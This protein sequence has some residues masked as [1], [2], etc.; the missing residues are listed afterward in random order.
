MHEKPKLQCTRDYQ[1]FEGHE[2]NR[3]LHEDGRLLES[4]RKCGFMP[5][6]PIQ[7]VRNGNG[8]FKVVRG[9]HRLDAAKRLKLPVWFVVDDSKVDIFDLEGGKQA[10]TG[11][12]FLSARAQAGGADYK[13][14]IQFREK[15]G[16]PL[17][18]AASL[19]GGHSA[20][21]GNMLIAVKDGTFKIA[22][23]QSHTNA[24]VSL[25]DFCLTHGVSFATSSSFVGAISMCLRVP[26]FD[27]ALFRHRVKLNGALLRKRSTRLDY[28]D[29]ID[30]LYNYAAKA[31]RVPLAFKAREVAKQRH[32]TF[33]GRAGGRS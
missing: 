32:D 28:L 2:F 31:S 24:V 10:W 3:P 11:A 17:A 18:Q 33:G 30:A 6:S 12:D 7:C 9:H 16:I 27:S 23:D 26:E 20:N 1:Q 5:S 13:R 22:A 21:S 29:E 25:T 15:H 8:K 14:L 19:L 4:M